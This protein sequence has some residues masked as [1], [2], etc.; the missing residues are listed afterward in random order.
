MNVTVAIPLQS[1]ASRLLRVIANILAMETTRKHAEETGEQM[2]MLLGEEA[3]LRPLPQ[4][5][6]RLLQRHLR[7]M[8]LM[9]A[10]PTPQATAHLLA[11]PISTTA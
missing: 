7:P 4:T 3:Q 8:S 5:F 9:A 6:R 10:T 2:C 11:P 1:E